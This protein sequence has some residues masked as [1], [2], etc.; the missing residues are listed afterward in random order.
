MILGVAAVLAV[1]IAW[2][3]GADLGRA[4]TVRLRRGWLVFAALGVQLVVFTG[5]GRLVPAGAHVPLH[6]ASYGLLV[7]FLLLN[8]RNL[9]LAVAGTGLF[10]NLVAIVANGGRMP[11][12]AAAWAE[13]N[14]SRGSGVYHNTTLAGGHPRLGWLGDVF[15]LPLGGVLGNAVSVGDLLVVFGL[16]VFV[17]RAGTTR[18]RSGF[19]N[20]LAP[21]RCG[22]FTRLLVGRSASR[23]GDWLTM[24]AVVTWTYAETHRASI[25]AVFLA[26]RMTAGVLGGIAAAPRLDRLPRARLLAAVEGGRG[27]VTLAMLPFAWHHQ[28]AAV[29]VLACVSSF[30]G[31][32]TN[33]SASSLVADLLPGRLFNAGNALNGFTRSAVM[34]GGALAGA[35]V[36]N[37]TG[38]GSA[39][40]VDVATFVLGAA[41]YLK[42]PV[43]T[44]VP[45]A[46]VRVENPR[47]LELARIILA[48]PIVFGLTASFTVVTASTGLLNAGLP[49]F[50]RSQLGE[51]RAYG[52]AL[53]A[54]GAGLMCGELLTGLVTREEVARRSVG[55]AFASMA[56]CLLVAAATGSLATAYLM[57]F[58]IGAS[59]GTTE[60]TYDTL[61]QRHLPDD[62]RAGVFALAGSV[63]TTGMIVGLSVAPL[64]AAAGGAAALRLS[65][66]GCLVGAAIAAGSVG[67]H[68]RWQAGRVAPGES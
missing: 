9:G 6:V 57:L 48:H 8:G 38:I 11:V 12:S 66:V 33:P 68:L 13:A 2:A 30:L 43:R 1:A 7:L 51:P 4:S 61:F 21:L 15:P 41:L 49:V 24:T 65:A 45:R 63:Q 52:Y 5:L 47:R 46:P 25:V 39:L 59:D 18:G 67:W 3:L 55:L 31:A 34:V 14:G 44:P 28:F 10:A 22:D 27:V 26:L 42:I 36:V 50:L 60:T 20:V 35:V 40:L 29:V 16:A 56:G 54:I 19:G 17:Y 62:V 64:V 37:S 58:L 32:A 53:A 23:L